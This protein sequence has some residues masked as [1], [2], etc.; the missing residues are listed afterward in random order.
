MFKNYMTTAIRNLLRH[1]Q[2]TLINIFGL[3]VGLAACMLILLYV[4]FELSYDRW[5]PHNDRVMR[6]QVYAYDRDGNFSGDEESIQP[7]TTPLFAEQID[8]IEL[9][10]RLLDDSVALAVDNQAYEQE[11]TIAD[12]DVFELMGIT[13]IEGDVSTALDNPDS[14]VL[15]ETDARR[16]FGNTSPLGRVV[17]INGE[18]DLRVTGVMP[19]WPHASDLNV[20]AFIPANTAVFDHTPWRLNSW[21]SFSGP[22]YFRLKEGVDPEVVA[23]E[24]NELAMRV[25]PSNRYK[26][27]VDRGMKPQHV[28]H[29]TKAVDAHL[30][31]DA[32]GGDGRGSMANLLT[33]GVIAFLILAIAVINVTNLGTMLAMKRVRE[34][35]IRKALGAEGRHLMVQVLVESV[36]LTVLSMLIGVAMAEASLPMFSELMNR[37]LTSSLIYEPGML[38]V[39]IGGTLLV[40]VVCGLY[41]AFVAVRFRPVDYLAGM[42]PKVGSRFR[43]VLIVAQFAATIGLLATCL[44]V[45]MQAEYA[46]TK[47]AGFDSSQLLVVSGTSR[48]VVLNREEALRD[49][50][51]RIE[52]V[53][54]VAASHDMPGHDYNNW[55]GLLLDNGNSIDV[56]RFAMSAD[57]LPMLGVKPLAGRLFDKNREADARTT[58]EHGA[59]GAIILNDLAARALGFATPEEAIGQEARTWGDFRSTIVGVVENL[60]V[61]SARSEPSPTYYWIGPHE[62]RHVVL[63]VRRQGMA[64]TLAEIDRVWREFFP[65]LP[66]RRQFV[67]ETFAEFYDTE[68]RQ[69]WLLLFSAGV[70]TAI[71]VMGLYGLAALATERR[72]KEIGIRK[73]LGAK[74][75]NIV[76]LLVWQFST[77]VLIANLIAWPIAWY[78][79]AQWLEGFIDRIGLTPWPFLVAGT[80]VLMVAWITII[81]HTLK[82]ARRSPIKALRYE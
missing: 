28:F 21:G 42:K 78:G 56:R 11:I 77:P 6:G 47:D 19:D 70:M 49:A 22:S 32:S 74:S 34:V 2:Y 45:F 54:G 1:K 41:P 18:H 82:V 29:L 68:R 72:S 40:G 50:F 51:A 64:D 58:P 3:A 35:A 24:M 26:D 63:K 71:A 5:I 61:R 52:G 13:L 10:S 23:K 60:R 27:R 55:N 39:L 66:I 17:K 80:A 25:G 16:I 30:K 8:G 67:D 14:I 20:N 31:S 7:V 15:S 59:S 9:Y 43:N 76:R 57:L 81:G 38:L 79:L 75:R 44:V 53:E 4:S 48:P 73:V 46:K 62:Y 12:P 69:G 65:D 37:A 33:A 36:S